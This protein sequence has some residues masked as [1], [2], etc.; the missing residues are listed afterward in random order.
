MVSTEPGPRTT[1]ALFLEALAR[2]ILYWVMGVF[3]SELILSGRVTPGFNLFMGVMLAV[4]DL[5]DKYRKPEWRVSVAPDQIL[6]LG[7]AII[8]LYAAATFYMWSFPVVANRH[9]L[10]IAGVTFLAWP[11]LMLVWLSIREIRQRSNATNAGR[12]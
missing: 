8:A 1:R 10:L 4:W 2:A 5:L 12:S 3:V 11:G 9:W 6:G 7:L